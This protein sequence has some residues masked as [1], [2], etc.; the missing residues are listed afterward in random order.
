MS[1]L[2]TIN[3]TQCGAGLSVLGG[4]RVRA[5]VCGYCGTVMD[6]QENY[7]LL[8]Q[9]RNM[10][11]PSSPFHIGMTGRMKGVEF[12]IIGM[13]GNEMQEDGETYS[14][15]DHQIYSP[16][17]GYCWLTWTADERKVTFTRRVRGMADRSDHNRVGLLGRRFWITEKYISRLTFCEGEFTWPPVVGE[18][19]AVTEAR[20][21]GDLLTVT[22]SA[23]GDDQ[24]EI[25]YTLTEEFDA[26]ATIHAFGGEVPAWASHYTFG[27]GARERGSRFGWVG[28]LV[29][30]AAVA[31]VMSILSIAL[32]YALETD[33]AKREFA[34]DPGPHEMTFEVASTER[35]HGIEL[36]TPV[37]NNWA[38]YDISLTQI[39]E[40]ESEID[41]AELGREIGYYFGGSGDDKWTEG[42]RY[43][44]IGFRPPAPGEY[45]L[46]IV[47]SEQG[48]GDTPLSVRV[49]DGQFTIIWLLMI[50]IG[51]AGILGLRIFF[52]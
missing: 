6:T 29:P 32:M 21:G 49:F 22:R 43:A 50:A 40:D 16:T 7:A 4:G 20:D 30:G 26:L 42:S 8:D 17:H 15:V 14:W 44:T 10:E 39:D 36:Y 24:A 5:Q 33:L 46:E 48:G 51:S 23:N 52:R 47:R 1:T 35:V 37:S 31:L 28:M 9:Y 45:A 11:R 18:E 27:R 25:E 19:T 38:Y 2:K 3:C 12:T 13:L 41:L 34:S